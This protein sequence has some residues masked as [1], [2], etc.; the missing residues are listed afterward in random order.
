MSWD[1]YC[2]IPAATKAV[3][4]GIDGT[5]WG[6]KGDWK[7]TKDENSKLAKCSLGSM[8]SVGGVK[9]MIVNKSGDVFF[10]IK[11]DDALTVIINTKCFLAAVGPKGNQGKLIEQIA[12]FAGSLKQGGY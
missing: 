2:N 6:K 7:S 4:S 5:Q 9:F 12:K 10:G 8:L 3:I 1:A 11:G